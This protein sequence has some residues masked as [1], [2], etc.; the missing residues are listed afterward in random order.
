MDPLV[1]MLIAAV[2][3]AG[4]TVYHRFA[5]PTAN[6]V[7]AT[8]VVSLIPVVFGIALLSQ[9]SISAATAMLLLAGISGFT[10]DYLALKHFFEG[11]VLG[12]G[13]PIILLGNTAL[14]T[15][16]AIFGEQLVNPLAVFGSL[17]IAA[18]LAIVV[19][20]R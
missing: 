10:V 14:A 7:I 16:V 18:G 17:L 5:N 1:I 8:V 4:W 11:A 12:K 3:W 6:E 15:I 9:Q 2:F 19:L 20:L 13:A